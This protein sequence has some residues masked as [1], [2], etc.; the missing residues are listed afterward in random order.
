MF[1]TFWSILGMYVVT[2]ICQRARARLHVIKPKT[3]THEMFTSETSKIEEATIK[4]KNKLKK[5][6]QKNKNTSRKP[7]TVYTRGTCCPPVRH[8]LALS[9]N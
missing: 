4:L 6:I 5:K 3:N 1:K 7:I 2:S 9:F 8:V